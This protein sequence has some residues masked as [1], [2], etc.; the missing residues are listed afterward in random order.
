MPARALDTLALHSTMGLWPILLVC[1]TGVM[2]K[3]PLFFYVAK[4][5]PC[6][7]VTGAAALFHGRMAQVPSTS[8]QRA[9]H[10][11]QLIW[12]LQAEA[13]ESSAAVLP[14]IVA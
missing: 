10:A 8:S 3:I 9:V 6:W 1:E 11:S 4:L 13:H 7:C 14:A 5:V 2:I 12:R